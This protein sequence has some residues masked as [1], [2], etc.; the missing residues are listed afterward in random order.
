[1]HHQGVTKFK[2]SFS[3]YL[4]SKQLFSFAKDL[5]WSSQFEQ[6]KIF[7]AF[8]HKNPPTMIPYPWWKAI[9]DCQVLS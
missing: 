7:F 5:S 3:L 1:M 2:N 8:F 6:Q 4:K 9:C